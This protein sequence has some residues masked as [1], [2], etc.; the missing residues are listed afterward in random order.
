MNADNHL[1]ELILQKSIIIKPIFTSSHKIGLLPTILI[2]S[3]KHILVDIVFRDLSKP[4]STFKVMI[5]LS[6]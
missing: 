3:H 2:N 6:V 5:L 4:G 1:N